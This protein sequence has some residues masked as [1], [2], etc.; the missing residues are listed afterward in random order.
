MSHRGKQRDPMGY[1]QSC[2]MQRLRHSPERPTHCSSRRLSTDKNAFYIKA[3]DSTPY[4]KAK[5]LRINAPPT[6]VFWCRLMSESRYI[7]AYDFT[8]LLSLRSI[9]KGSSS[10]AKD[11]SQLVLVCTKPERIYAHAID[12]A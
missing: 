12:K 6:E 9:S 8:Q 3:G 7:G 5:G 11:A 1:K 2:V 4:G 10:G